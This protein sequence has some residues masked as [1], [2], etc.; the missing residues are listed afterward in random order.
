M[1]WKEKEEV[2]LDFYNRK[3]DILI[4]T[5]VIEVGIDVPNASVIVIE[6]ADRFG[7]SQLHQL[8]GRVGRGAE[9][10]YC[11]LITKDEFRI[12]VGGIEQNEIEKK[13]AIIRLKTMV[14]TNDGF[15]RNVNMTFY[16]DLYNN[17]FVNGSEGQDLKQGE[18]YKYVL[19]TKKDFSEFNK[20]DFNNLT[21][22]IV[23]TKNYIYVGGSNGE[24]D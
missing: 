14:K 4:A 19:A 24:I 23:E 8:R 13:A 2:M 12:K 22:M 11:F 3:F 10:S 7:L 20:N 5:T 17:I 18:L 6:N 21:P 16:T 1:S 15:E 9:Q